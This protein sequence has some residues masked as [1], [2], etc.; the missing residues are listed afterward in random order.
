[1]YGAVICF[2][3]ILPPELW[4]SVVAYG[5]GPNGP[6]RTELKVPDTLRFPAIE[7]EAKTSGQTNVWRLSLP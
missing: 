7:V 5:T 2:G 1:V 6:F 4:R 3:P